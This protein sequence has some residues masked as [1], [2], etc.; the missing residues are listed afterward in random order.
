M[1]KKRG[2]I[3]FLLLSIFLT[4]LAE[5]VI[6]HSHTEENGIVVPDWDNKHEE[7]QEEH[8]SE[9]LH[10]SF[11]QL[12]TFDY[13]LGKTDIRHIVLLVFIQQKVEELPIIPDYNILSKII[14]SILFLVHTSS[15][16]A[17]PLYG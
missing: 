5:K 17:P 4:V 14:N 15:S 13:S 8:D 1:N 12:S 3:V 10:S 16:K 6:P 11:Y 2:H 9:E 7:S